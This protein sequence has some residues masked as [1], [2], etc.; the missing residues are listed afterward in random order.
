M[1]EFI[2]ICTFDS[3]PEKTGIRFK[4]DNSD[5]AIFKINNKI[6]VID[7]ICPHNQSPVLFEGI[8]KHYKISCPF[9]SWEFDLKT[10]SNTEG[11]KQI[12]IFNTKIED[13]ILFVKIK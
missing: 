1:S 4:Y 3:I 11:F 10:G 6:F 9:H 12:R 7:N 2:K 8:L 13:N 5:L